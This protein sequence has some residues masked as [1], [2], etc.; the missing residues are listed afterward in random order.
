MKLTKPLIIAALVAGSLF[1]GNLAMQ[2]Q[3]ATNAPPAGAPPGP[4]GGMRGGLNLDRLTTELNLTDDQK[5]KVKAILEDHAK[6]MKELRDSNP[7]PEDRRTK[8]QSIRKDMNDKLKEVLTDE[9]FTKYQEMNRGGRRNRAGGGN[10]PANP[11]Q[12]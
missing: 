2:A 10:P 6:Q 1:A 9:Q 8:M 7:T 11:P 5:P 12:N 4:R 3:D